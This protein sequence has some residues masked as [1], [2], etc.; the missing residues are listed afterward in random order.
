MT[1]HIFCISV[2]ALSP[3][4]L[5]ALPPDDAGKSVELAEALNML[6]LASG[7]IDNLMENPENGI[8]QNLFNQS[9]ALVIFP[10]ACQVAAGA[11]NG[12]GGKGIAMI[13]QEDGSW[14]NPIFVTL[15][16]GNL[17][18]RIGAQT[19]DIVL[20][21]QNKNDIIGIDHSAIILG[22]DVGIAVG[23]DHIV[24][25]PGPDNTFKTGIYSYHLNEGLFTGVN[26]KGAILSY[27]GKLDDSLWMMANREK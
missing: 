7:T 5:L 11:F 24:S 26:I 1:L 12:A 27:S 6:E 25:S 22:G 10:R 14:S 20:L 18:F 21:V 9:E 15:H 17:G 19:S 23:P 16:E 4:T 3:V 2:L 8:P 13:F